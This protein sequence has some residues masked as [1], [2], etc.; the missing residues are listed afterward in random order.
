[1]SRR[2]QAW[3]VAIILFHTAID[4]L[5][6][7]AHVGEHV[8]SFTLAQIL[9]I[10][11]VIFIAPLMALF[12]LGRRRLA[13]GGW[14]FF[15]SMLGS[16]LFGVWSHFVMPGADNIASLSSGVWK[17]PFQLTSILLTIIDA[18]GTIVGALFLCLVLR[19]PKER[20]KA[21]L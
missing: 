21:A 4:V 8:L 20:A 7:G 18:V 10:T 2:I 19:W 9:F 12:L 17:V 15:L 5:H 14:W 16:L 11:I 13:W 1:M 3:V 6:G